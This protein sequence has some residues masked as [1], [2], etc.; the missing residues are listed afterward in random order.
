ML[1]AE[2]TRVETVLPE[3]AATTMH[4]VDVLGVKKMC[5]SDGFA[6]SLFIA[7]DSDQM[8]VVGHQAKSEDV[9]APL[10]RLPLQHFKIDVLVVI[11]EEN[12]LTV[13]PPLDNV[14]R[15]TFYYYSCKPWHKL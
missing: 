3:V 4:A 2:R 14:M 7:G 1:A 11:D 8:D 10:L 15:N 6:K 9:K 12:I 5:S 13:V